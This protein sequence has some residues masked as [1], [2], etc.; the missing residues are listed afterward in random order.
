MDAV[1]TAV[2]DADTA[3]R[4][5]AILVL[6][7]AHRGDQHAAVATHPTGMRGRLSM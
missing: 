2:L 6:L 3:A 5:D 4:S 7:Q 1:I